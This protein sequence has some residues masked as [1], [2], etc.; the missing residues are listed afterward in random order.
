MNHREAKVLW[1][2]DDAGLFPHIVF[3]GDT[4]A[5]TAG[6][7]S[8]T[9]VSRQEVVIALA[10]QAELNAGQSG[11]PA[12]LS[13]VQAALGRND[14]REVRLVRVEPRPFAQG[15]SF[16]SFRQSAWRPKLFY[17]ALSGSG[18]AVPE[19]EESLE[20]FLANGGIVTRSDA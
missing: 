14:L 6:W 11:T 16:K 17:S 13:R 5:L 4:D 8:F 2:R 15:T 20:A 7:V 9:S 10:T 1:L 18:E 12:A 19:R 3:S